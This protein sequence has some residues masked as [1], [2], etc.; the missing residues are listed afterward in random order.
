MQIRR[1]YCRSISSPPVL[2]ALAGQFT[3]LLNTVSSRQADI[4]L[5]HFKENEPK[6]KRII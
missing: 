1:F 2:K 6:E 4:V 3:V 5:K